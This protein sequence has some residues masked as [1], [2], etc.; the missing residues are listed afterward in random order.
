MRLK[1]WLSAGG[2]G[3][4]EPS[5][6]VASAH[7]WKPSRRSAI[8]ALSPALSAQES[9]LTAWHYFWYASMTQGILGAQRSPQLQG[10]HQIRLKRRSRMLCEA[11]SCDWRFNPPAEPAEPVTGSWVRWTKQ[12]Q[13]KHI[14][15]MPGHHQ[16]AKVSAGSLR[17]AKLQNVL[18][19]GASGYACWLAHVWH[20]RWP[21]CM[22]T[23][24]VWC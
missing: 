6:P 20:K 9:S 17:N 5:L 14:P 13:M 1:S 11:A 22:S 19:Q 3:R 21:D 4:I 16:N 18:R 15:G 2:A 7:H 8:G 10:A 24:K 23:D 12:S